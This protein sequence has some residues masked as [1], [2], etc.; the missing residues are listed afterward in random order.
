MLDELETILSGSVYIVEVISFMMWVNLE[1]TK[2]AMFGISTALRNGDV[3]KAKQCLNEA[4][5][6][7][8]AA[9][10]EWLVLYGFPASPSW[11]AYY[12]FN[13]MAR[14]ALGWRGGEIADYELM[15]SLGYRRGRDGKWRR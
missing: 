8:N 12:A 10:W 5:V 3:E 2:F 11:P 13:Y 9:I 6:V 1:G 7:A 4:G 14:I 15:T